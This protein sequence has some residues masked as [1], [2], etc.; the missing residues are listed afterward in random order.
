[1]ANIIVSQKDAHR[2]AS[3]SSRDEATGCLVWSGA[4]FQNGYGAFKLGRQERRAHR[5]AWALAH[6]EIPAGMLV[7]HACDNRACV[8]PSHLFLGTHHDNMADMVAKGR[9]ARGISNGAARR[10]TTRLTA[11]DVRR[12]R[13]YLRD[14]LS[15]GE[16]A[17]MFGTS[18][19]NVSYIHRGINWAHVK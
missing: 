3:K 9:A 8:E 15:Q 10:A 14:G 13:L 16:V 4:R 17:M 1:M 18:Q 2:F 5:V 6:G 11:A 19:S 12:I 7:L